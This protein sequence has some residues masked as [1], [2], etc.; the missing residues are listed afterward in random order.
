MIAVRSEWGHPQMHI[1][2][3]KTEEHVTIDKLIDTKQYN[4]L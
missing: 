4:T 3:E 1:I 2:P